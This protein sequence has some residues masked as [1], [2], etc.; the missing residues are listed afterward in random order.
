MLRAAH[1]PPNL[2]SSARIYASKLQQCRRRCFLRKAAK[3]FKQFV[4]NSLKNF[5]KAK[6]I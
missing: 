5:A 1:K 2:P 3:V 4:P 6:L